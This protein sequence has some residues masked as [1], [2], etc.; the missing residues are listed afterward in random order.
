MNG[1]N[2]P[3]LRDDAL[4]HTDDQPLAFIIDQVV[5]YPLEEAFVDL[6]VALDVAVQTEVE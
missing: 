2:L 3:L 6:D 4:P 5:L 1:P